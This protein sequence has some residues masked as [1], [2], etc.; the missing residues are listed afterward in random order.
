MIF[1][2]KDLREEKLQKIC[3]PYMVLIEK[4]PYMILVQR[5][6]V[7]VDDSLIGGR[8]WQVEEFF[9]QFVQ[10][11]KIE[12][13]GQLKKHLGIWWEWKE[14]H[15]L[16]RSL[17]EGINAEDGTGDQGGIHGTMGKPAKPTKTL[18]YP[19]NV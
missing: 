13:L 16:G 3:T 14:D 18:G 19:G 11:F 8:K 7:H 2:Q 10:Y 6:I 9:R 5:E 1:V 17:L 15:Q 4:V 12:R